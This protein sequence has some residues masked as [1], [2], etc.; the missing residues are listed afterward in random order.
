MPCTIDILLS[1]TRFHPRLPTPMV[2]DAAKKEMQKYKETFHHLKTNHSCFIWTT[3]FAQPQFS[4]LE[5]SE[6][7][8]PYDTREYIL[9]IFAQ[10]GQ[11]IEKMRNKQIVDAAFDLGFDHDKTFIKDPKGFL[12]ACVRVMETT[13]KFRNVYP[14][15]HCTANHDDKSGMSCYNKFCKLDHN[16]NIE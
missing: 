12:E 15:D 2:A 1:H 7:E 4:M 16:W 13:D 8:L 11:G 6:F 3:K 9:S 10:M 5:W 14:K